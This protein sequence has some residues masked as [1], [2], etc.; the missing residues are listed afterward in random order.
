MLSLRV[1]GQVISYPW[2]RATDACAH[3]WVLCEV[4]LLWSFTMGIHGKYT[5]LQLCGGLRITYW[6]LDTSRLASQQGST[7]PQMISITM[8][9]PSYSHR[10]SRAW[11]LLSGMG[12]PTVGQRWTCPVGTTCN[13]VSFWPV[14]FQSMP[15]TRKLLESSW[16]ESTHP[17]PSPSL[18]SSPRPL[19]FGCWY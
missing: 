5:L 3:K 14:G 6:T 18:L 1:N 11:G 2:P 12:N 9:L 17:S 10:C 8:L 19:P 13:L 16:I 4:S 7:K 15:W